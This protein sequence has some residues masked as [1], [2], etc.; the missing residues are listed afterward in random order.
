LA[1]A[2]TAPSATGVEELDEFEEIAGLS[3]DA[4]ALEEEV[5]FEDPRSRLTQSS[6]RRTNDKT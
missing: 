6:P 4:C 2:R 3:E 1:A 5:P